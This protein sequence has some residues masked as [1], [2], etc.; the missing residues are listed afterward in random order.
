MQ[1]QSSVI[2]I[3]ILVTFMG[4]REFTGRRDSKLPLMFHILAW[5]AFINCVHLVKINTCFSLFLLYFNKK[6]IFQGTKIKYL[7]LYKKQQ[8]SW[9][10][11]QL[12][13]QNHRGIRLCMGLI[14][15][16]V[17]IGSSGRLEDYTEAQITF[18]DIIHCLCTFIMTFCFF[19]SHFILSTQFPKCLEEIC[20]IQGTNCA[21]CSWPVD[22]TSRLK[23]KELKS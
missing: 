20:L 17:E 19:I 2:E 14:L 18:K 9:E 3:R 10:G 13:L 5:M 6:F 8:L 4:R 1:K 12:F 22:I 21:A 7:L 15:P 16:Q 11:G 23:K